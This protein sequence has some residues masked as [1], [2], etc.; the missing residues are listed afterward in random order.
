M[1]RY[2]LCGYINREDIPVKRF[3]TRAKAEKRLEKMLDTYHLE[4]NEIYNGKT[5]HD[6]IYSCN[7]GTGFHI[8]R[9]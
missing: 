1:K 3:W 8:K 5:H 4:I 2:V 9:Q 6:K 7:D